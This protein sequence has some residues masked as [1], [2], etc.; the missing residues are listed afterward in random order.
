MPSTITLVKPTPETLL[1]IV[2]RAAFLAYEA[3]EVVGMGRYQA[4]DG[5]TENQLFADYQGQMD[6]AYG[7]QMKTY[8]KSTTDGWSIQCDIPR[9]TYQSWCSKYSTTAQLWEA[10][11]TSLKW[12]KG[13]DYTIS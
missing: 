13:V 9:P 5:I 6:Y 2:K 1:A 10:A 8:I 7:R 4:R 11:A 3:S 12:V